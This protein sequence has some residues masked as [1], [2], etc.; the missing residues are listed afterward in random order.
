MRFATLCSTLKLGRSSPRLV[1]GPRRRIFKRLAREKSS[2][3]KRVE[4]RNSAEKRATSS[5]P[6]GSKSVE[7]TEIACGHELMQ[8]LEFSHI[9]LRAPMGRAARHIFGPTPVR[10]ESIPASD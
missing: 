6:I 3:S 9:F 2:F 10:A 5:R 7:R 1:K 8:V 4:E